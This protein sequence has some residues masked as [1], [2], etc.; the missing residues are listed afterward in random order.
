MNA[1]PHSG[2]EP[3]QPFTT[4]IVMPRAR[5]VAYLETVV[6]SL[7]LRALTAEDFRAAN[8]LLAYRPHLLITELQLEE[9]NGL[10][11]VLHARVARPSLAAVVTSRWEDAVLQRDAE[12]M[13]ATFVEI[14]TSREELTAAILRTVTNSGS[15]LVESIRPPFERRRS[16]R[17]A[18]IHRPVEM[19]RRLA[20][21]RR[22]LASVLEEAA[23]RMIE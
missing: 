11:L 14:P 16:V 6:R 5:E 3:H 23:G 13:G 15:A 21:R 10:N 17:R 9:Y 22:E 20:Q 19:E 8:R 18:D 2:S 4:L 7:G 1:L 12:T